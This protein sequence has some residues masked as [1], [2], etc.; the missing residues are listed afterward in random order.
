MYRYGDNY[1]A[2]MTSS[3]A[4]RSYPSLDS[5]PLRSPVL[6]PDLDLDL[7]QPEVV[8]YLRPLGQ[9]QILLAVK[10]LKISK[11]ISLWQPAFRLHTFSSS[12]SCS[13]VKAVLLLLVFPWQPGCRS[14]QPPSMSSLP[15][16]SSSSLLQM[17]SLSSGIS[18]VSGEK[19]RE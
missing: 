13:L 14:P 7:G 8:R 2:V 10:L 1:L 11:L 15:M 6:E 17:L 12:R 9:T 4:S 19:V 5:L 16:S 18:E 3:A